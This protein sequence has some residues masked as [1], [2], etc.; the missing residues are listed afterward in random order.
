MT[1]AAEVLPEWV[2]EALAVAAR[3]RLS[4]DRSVL[5]ERHAARFQSL[6]REQRLWLAELAGLVAEVERTQSFTI[7]GHRTVTGWCRALS[8][9]SSGQ[10]S[11]WRRV[12]RVAAAV[13]EIAEALEAG[14]LG[15]EQAH[16]L[17][18]VHANRRV[19]NHLPDYIDALLQDAARSSFDEFHSTLRQWENV[20]DEDGPKPR[21]ERA[22]RNRFAKI[23]VD[24]YA[25]RITAAL[26]N[27]DGAEMEE[28]LA[29]YCDAEFRADCDAARRQW[30]EDGYLGHLPRTARQRAADAMHR[31]F[32]DA[33]SAQTG[34]PTADP[35][36]NVT[37]DVGTFEQLLADLAA[38]AADDDL[39]ADVVDTLL[40]DD[41]DDADDTDDTDDAD[42]DRD[43]LGDDIDDDIDDDETVPAARSTVAS[44]VNAAR[45][46]R[47]QQQPRPTRGPMRRIERSPDPRW[48]RCDSPSG[49]PLPRAAALE[50]LLLGHV[51][52]IVVDSAGV[53]VDAGRR[54]R[55][56]TGVQRDMVMRIARWCTHPGCTV[57]A[58]HCQADHTLDHQHGGVTSTSNGGPRC[59]YHNRSKNRGYTVW[60]DP[61]GRWHTYHPDGT[62]VPGH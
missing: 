59:G 56:F 21:S 51:R 60:L 58:R 9:C 17:G 18:R 3:T 33:A 52:R 30:G 6:V 38:D 48:W 15:V 46:R 4:E 42:D 10:A 40:H 36:L 34:G 23:E 19:A 8:Q 22:H 49:T 1:V 53:V 62:E 24:A 26:G 7:D 13:P 43:E 14:R 35:L 47:R 2:E 31:L 29:R 39:L 50:A 12:A 16:E 55:L 25:T 20:L 57:P 27:T 45:I 5:A 11:Q 32:L 37:I 54:R 44:A 41:A 61:D 28:I